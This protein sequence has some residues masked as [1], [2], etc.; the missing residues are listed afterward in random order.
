MN[1]ETMRSSQFFVIYVPGLL[2]NNFPFGSFTKEQIFALKP[3][4]THNNDG[5]PYFYFNHAG[6]SKDVDKYLNEL[7]ISLFP[8]LENLDIL[9]TLEITNCIENRY[10]FKDYIKELI[11]NP[12]TTIPSY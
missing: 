4:I 1:T 3:S 6:L 7:K 9:C 5:K 11:K 8:V 12:T 2:D 10:S